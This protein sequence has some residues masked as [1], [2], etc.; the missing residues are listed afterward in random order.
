MPPPKAEPIERGRVEPP[1]CWETHTPHTVALMLNA[2]EE[3]LVL[4][5]C[6]SLYKF[7]HEGEMNQALLMQYDILRLL[8][9][10]LQHANRS[11]RRMAAMTLS[12]LASNG[13]VQAALLSDGSV[14]TL[15]AILGRDDDHV[16]DEFVSGALGKMAAEPVGQAA[17]LAEDAVPALV[18]RLVSPDPDVLKNCLDTLLAILHDFQAVRSLVASDGI[19]RALA[20][21]GVQ[22]SVLFSMALETL[23]KAMYIEEGRQRLREVGGLEDLLAL[24]EDAAQEAQFARIIAVLEHA[25]LDTKNVRVMHHNGGLLRMVQTARASGQPEVLAQCGA[26]IGHL[27]GDELCRQA[28]HEL[29]A[30]TVIVSAML[31]S[32]STGSAPLLVAACEALGVLSLSL[33]AR[34]QLVEHAGVRQLLRLLDSDYPAVRTAAA[35]PPAQPTSLADTRLAEYVAYVRTALAP[36]ES[37]QRQGNAL[38]ELVARWLGGAVAREQLGSWSPEPHLEE[39]RRRHASNVLPVGDVEQAGLRCRALLYKFLADQMS[40]PCTLNRGSYGKYWNSVFVA[41]NEPGAPPGAYLE[42]VVDLIHQPG[43]MMTVG[44]KEALEYTTGL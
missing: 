3:D 11:V 31:G 30:E 42:Q 23:R 18:A 17:L 24:L 7:A 12:E 14:A 43:R 19:E 2:T 29:G 8:L 41:N 38:A 32:A 44:T 40:L 34:R 10:H 22:H 20:L 13:A 15:V 16:V 27:G 28:L 6:Q 33:R 35:S 1:F 4:K 36:L 9:G 39:L 21:R 26:V 25:S 5:A 37:D